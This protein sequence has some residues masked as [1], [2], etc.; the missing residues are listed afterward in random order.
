MKRAVIYCR[1]AT[2]NEGSALKLA[3]QEE[4]CRAFCKRLGY[5]VIEVVDDEGKS[6]ARLNRPGLTRVRELTSWQ[7]RGSR[8]AEARPAHAGN[9]SL[10]G[11]QPGVLGSCREVVVRG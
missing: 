5:D 7:C 6:G 4:R 2:V 9:Q 10:H 8:H 1:T 11:T 3:A